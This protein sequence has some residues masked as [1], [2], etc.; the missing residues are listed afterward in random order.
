MMPI[1]FGDNGNA[2]LLPE[3][4]RSWEFGV[5]QEVG[6]LE[7]AATWFDQTFHDLIQYTSQTTEPTDPNYVNVGAAD[8]VGLELSADAA[9]GRVGLSGS[10]TRLFTEVLDPG[11][12]ANATFVEGE[13]LLRRPEHSGSLS[14]RVAGERTTLGVSMNAVGDRIDVDYGESFQGER[15]TLPGYTTIDLFSRVALPWGSG[16]DLLARV[17]NAL[18]AEYEGIARFPAPGRIV[19]I[20]ARLTIGGS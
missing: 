5:E 13:A 1:P 16:V 6:P 14:A 17:E 8:A 7:L 9:I 10:Y 12:A 11:L 4:I 19:R 20:G 2:G 15:V 18:D 3:R